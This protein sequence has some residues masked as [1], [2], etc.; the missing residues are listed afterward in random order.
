MLS[1]VLYE[2]PKFMIFKHKDLILT[3][4]YILLTEM[5]EN[6]IAKS[7]KKSRESKKENL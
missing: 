3:T 1:T 5:F 7:L 4:V 6:W 2:Q